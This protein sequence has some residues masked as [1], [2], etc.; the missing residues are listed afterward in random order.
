[1]EVR[2]VNQGS[3]AVLQSGAEDRHGNSCGSVQQG[4]GEVERNVGAGEE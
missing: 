3:D 2:A 4:G 1:M